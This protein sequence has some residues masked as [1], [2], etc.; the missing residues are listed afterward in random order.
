[1]SVQE[2]EGDKEVQIIPGTSWMKLK[3]LRQRLEIKRA[4]GKLCEYP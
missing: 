4:F 1:M 3:P 2:L